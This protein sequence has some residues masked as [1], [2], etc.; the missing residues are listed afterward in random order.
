MNMGCRIM[1]ALHTLLRMPD[2]R[3]E[4]MMKIILRRLNDIA[5]PF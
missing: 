1:Q 5:D 2:S 3:P 4:A